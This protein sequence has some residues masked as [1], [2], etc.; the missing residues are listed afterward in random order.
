MHARHSYIWF[1]NRKM[2]MKFNKPTLITLTAPTA[3]GKSYLLERL[4]RMGLP[5]VVGTTTRAPRQG[6]VEGVDYYFITPLL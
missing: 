6:E 2:K 1:H 4:T 5:R 3:S